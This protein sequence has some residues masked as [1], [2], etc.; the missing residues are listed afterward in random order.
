MPPNGGTM[1][2]FGGCGE[3]APPGFAPAPAVS[4]AVP[5]IVGLTLVGV[6]AVGALALR[7]LAV[8][9]PTP[10]SGSQGHCA[11]NLATHAAFTA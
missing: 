9:L 4:G 3:P 2:A 8:E 10:S 1:L 6:R 11:S 5:C 7:S